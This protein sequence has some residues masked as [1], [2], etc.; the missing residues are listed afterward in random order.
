MI[1]KNHSA[2]EAE[3]G[4][5]RETANQRLYLTG[6]GGDIYWSSEYNQLHIAKIAHKYTLYEVTWLS[7]KSALGIT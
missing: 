3:Q 4:L 6:D 7:V 2:R 1:Y 5:C